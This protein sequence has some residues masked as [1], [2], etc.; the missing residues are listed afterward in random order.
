[1][2]IISKMIGCRAGNSTGLSGGTPV[3][4]ALASRVLGEGALV[5]QESAINAYE[6][7]EL[8]N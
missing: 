3:K 7:T 8:F 4:W 6:W 2:P 5:P 1:M